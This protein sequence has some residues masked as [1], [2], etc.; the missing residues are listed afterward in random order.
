MFEVALRGRPSDDDP[1]ASEDLGRMLSAWRLEM[2]AHRLTGSSNG[3]AEGL[4]LLVK[5]TKRV[6]H[7]FTVFDNYRLRILLHT[8]GVSWPTRPTSPLVLHPSTGFREEPLSRGVRSALRSA[9]ERRPPQHGHDGTARGR[10]GDR[11]ALRRVEVD[12]R[13]PGGWL[14]GVRPRRN[15]RPLSRQRWA[16]Q[17]SARSLSRNL[18]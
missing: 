16:R 8:G 14:P 4:N 5:N 18:T 6:G 3:P 10:S 11:A 15:G 1:M 12:G 7:G 2:L 17:G 13:T 9:S